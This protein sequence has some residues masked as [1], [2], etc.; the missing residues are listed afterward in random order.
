MTDQR[1]H[2]VL[3]DSATYEFEISMELIVLSV[4]YGVVRYSLQCPGLKD[5]QYA[6]QRGQEFKARLRDVLENAGVWIDENTSFADLGNLAEIM[7]MRRGNIYSFKLDSMDVMIIH[8]L[9]RIK[10]MYPGDI[11]LK[12]PE[13]YASVLNSL[14]GWCALCFGQMGFTAEEIEYMETALVDT[15]GYIAGTEITSSEGDQD[16]C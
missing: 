15:P 4:L 2:Q 10:E 14:R 7:E 5:F 13:S 16:E 1:V 9:L 8:G 12:S 3:T 6:E 11:E